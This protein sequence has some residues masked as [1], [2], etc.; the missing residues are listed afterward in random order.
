[1]RKTYGNTWWGKEFLNS[2]ANIDLTNLDNLVFS[3]IL[4]PSSNLAIVPGVTKLIWPFDGTNTTEMA[5]AD[6][7][8]TGDSMAWDLTSFFDNSFLRNFEIPADSNYALI[9]IKFNTQCLVLPGED[10][11][12]N[13]QGDRGCG[14]TH[15]S[16]DVVSTPFSVLGLKPKANRAV[17][18]NLRIDTVQACDTA[19][20]IDIAFYNMYAKVSRGSEVIAVTFPA[21]FD[22]VGS[23]YNRH[24]DSLLDTIAPTNTVTGNLRT[25]EWKLLPGMPIDPPWVDSL[26]FS[27]SIVPVTDISCSIDTL[28][29]AKTF[30]RYIL[31]CVS[32]SSVPC[33]VIYNLDD[34][35]KA[36]TVTKGEFGFDNLSAVL[37]GCNDSIDVAFDYTNSGSAIAA[38]TQTKFNI[39]ADANGNGIY[40]ITDPIIDSIV[41]TN[42]IPKGSSGSF[43]TTLSQTQFAGGEIC[44]LIVML[45]SNSSCVCDTTFAST[46]VSIDMQLVGDT[47]CDNDTS[48]FNVC[49]GTGNYAA[50]TYT[51]YDVNGSGRHIY[52][53]DVNS[54]SPSF[55]PPVVT[56]DSIFTFAIQVNRGGCVSEDTIEILVKAAP[57]PFTVLDD[58]IC[59]GTCANL[60]TTMEAGVTYNVYDG[61]GSFLGTLPYTACPSST[62]SY[63][64]EAVDPVTSCGSIRDTAIIT[65]IN[66]KDP[67]SNAVVSNCGIGCTVNLFS[68]LIGTPDTTGTWT[69]PSGAPFGIGH[70]VIFSSSTDVAGIYTYT[71]SNPPCNDTSSTVT[72]LQVTDT[73]PVTIPEDSTSTLCPPILSNLGSIDT[74]VVSCLP[75]NGT[76]T[77]DTMTGCMTYTPD[78]NYIGNDTLCVVTCDTLGI[79]DTAV[80]TITVVPVIDT[81]PLTVDEDDEVT[82]CPPSTTNVSPIGSVVV[83]CAPTHGTTSTDPTTGCVTYSP[84]SSYVGEDTLCIIICNT[85]GICDTTIVPITVVP[86]MDTVPTT[87][88]EDVPFTLCPPALTVV[89]SVG[90]FTL[91]C[92]PNNGTTS[93]DTA[94][95]CIT[96]TPS[97]NFSGLDTLCII[98]CDINGVC[99]TTLVPVTVTSE[100]DTIPVTIPE[101]STITLCPPVLSGVSPIGSISTNCGP[102]SGTV[103]LDTMTGCMTYKPD[104]NYVGNDTICVITCDTLSGICDTTVVT[105]TVTP[106]IDTVPVT[107]DEDTPFTICPPVTTSVDAIGSVTVSCGPNHGIPATDPTTG[108]VTYTPDSNYVGRD[109]ICIVT[110][111]TAGV[112]DTTIVP[113]TVVPVQDTL[114]KYLQEDSTITLCAPEITDVD[115]FD[116]LTVLCAPA[117]GTTSVDLINGCISY[118]ADPNFVG[119]DTLCIV[120]CDTNGICDTTIIEFVVGPVKDTLYRTILE[121]DSL[122][123]CPPVISNLGGTITSITSYCGPNQGTFTNDITTGCIVYKPDTNYVGQDSLCVVTCDNFSNCDTTIVI[124]TVIPVID[125]IPVTIPEDSS[126]TICPPNTTDTDVLGT[127]STVCGPNHG[128][129][130][131]DPITGCVSYEADS[132]YVGQDTICVVTCNSTGVCD[133]TPIVITVV[134][135]IDTL[136]IT[137]PED[138]SFTLCPP[139]L[140]DVDSIGTIT[141]G[142]VTSGTTTVDTATS[143]VT[144]N[145]NPSFSGR[146]TVCIIICDINGVCDT[147]IVPI[148]VTP[149]KD[150]VLVTI[151]ED[152]TTT[153]C[154]PVLSGISPIGS[155]ATFCDPAHGVVTLDTTTGCMTYNPDTNYVGQDSVCVVTCD[156]ISGVCDSTLVV[157]TITPVVDTVPVTIPEDSSYTLCPPFSTDVDNLGAAATI[158]GPNNGSVSI[159]F[160]TG[161]VTY[162]PDSSYVGQDTICILICNTSGVCDTTPL[163]ITIVP[164]I[165][166]VPVTIPEDSTITLCPPTVT[167][168]DSI[169]SVSI[170]CGP[171][172]GTTIIDSTTGC[173][174]YTPDSSFSGADTVCIVICNIDSICDTTVVV[175]KVTPETDSVPVVTLEDVPL[176]IA[177]PTLSGIT[178]I[179]TITTTGGPTHGT[180]TTDSITG[181]IT[182]TPDT[183]Y[184]GFDTVTVITCDTVANICDTTFVSITVLPV[185][186][187]VPMVIDE[188]SSFT[189][190][191]R[192]DSL[193]D[194]DSLGGTT[195][196]DG[197]NF[198]TTTVDP[199]TGAVTYKSD[200]NFVGRDSIVVE[201]CDTIAGFCDTTLITVFVKPV[202]DT[203]INDTIEIDTSLTLCPPSITVVDSIGSM[204][205][206]CPPMFGS[207]TFDSTT[208][209]VTYTPI[210]GYAGTDTLCFVIC[211]TAGV[212]DTTSLFVEILLDIDTVPVI[213]D[214][215]STFTLC[216]PLTTRRRSIADLDT[217]CSPMH[218]TVTLDTITGCVTYNPDTNYIGYDTVCIV[219]TDT[220]GRTDTTIITIT[221]NPILDTITLKVDEDTPLVIVPPTTTGF[222][223]LGGV[224]V[225]NGPKFGTVTTD[226]IT[227]TV[228]YVP[229][230]NFVGKDTIEIVITDGNGFSDTT[231]TVICVIPVRDTLY[232]SMPADSTI[233]VC[234]PTTTA[235]DSLGS[236]SVLC[237][238]SHGTATTDAAGCLTYIGDST[239]AGN[240]TLCVVICDTAGVCDTTTLVITLKRVFI[241]FT[242]ADDTICE[243]SCVTLMADTMQ[244]NVIY[245]VH[246]PRGTVIGRLPSATVCPTTDSTFYIEAYDTITGVASLWDTATIFVTKF[247]SP[248]IDT[249]IDLC[250]T[251]SI[252]N[253]FDSLGGTPDTT[254]TWTNPNGNPFGTRYPGSFDPLVDT[255][256]VYTYTI[257]NPVCPDTSATV[258]INKYDAPNPGM[259]DTLSF[260]QNGG[261]TDLFNSL[262]GTPDNTGNWSGPSTTINGHLGTIDLLTADT[263]LYWYKVAKRG[264]ADDS[265]HVKVHIDTIED[266]SIMMADTALCKGLESAQVIVLGAK[267]GTFSMNSLAGDNI[268]I[269]P[270]TGELTFSNRLPFRTRSGTYEVYY[271]TAGPCPE[272][273]TIVITM[274]E[275]GEGCQIEIPQLI[276]PNG[277]GK[278]DRF[279]IPGIEEFPNNV[280]KIYNRW[281]NL[282][283]EANRYTNDWEGKT[284]VN[285]GVNRTLGSGMLPVGTYFYIFEPNDDR[286]LPFSGYVYIKK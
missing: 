271:T 195:V 206:L 198:G 241:P 189:V 180:V 106:V 85:T 52:L 247:R 182:Y 225:T 79:C 110:C 17:D 138:S 95:S 209:C 161:C 218:G 59:A 183:N 267:G 33:E 203:I 41:T 108:C 71:I 248:G 125:T 197:P 53:S 234:M 192:T 72:I 269:D 279:I 26:S 229:D 68:S 275:Y 76:V 65:V 14:E 89:D 204:T 104:T 134:P 258:T 13:V 124:I 272:T 51:W 212:C 32:D 98:I 170:A 74:M 284:N 270:V 133:T 8:I 245:R 155:I 276:T 243:G 12:F 266:P 163:V 112:C 55:I 184:V 102:T 253:L 158:C 137:I 39:V 185:M 128:T 130:T 233:V 6:P 268:S 181:S 70:N 126:F 210:I 67:G 35:N 148:I 135:V 239:Y 265:A 244:S 160:A 285:T 84:D 174:T 15:L 44:N 63:Y 122:T 50:R 114:I 186:D 162:T 201:V 116:T 283:Y 123:I 219:T 61:L 228:T 73:I 227:G 221:I 232:Y 188:D 281:G 200:P 139:A 168:V 117:N 264:C 11:R 231:R 222:D 193:T 146:D 257:V 177:P 3:A 4:P 199:I 223:S 30:E 78:T 224:A 109:T 261:T 62:S 187:T 83:D 173:V 178:P 77:L 153:L 5:V 196:L 58:T 1:M 38:G 7:T 34:I 23:I 19:T 144:Y 278:N 235:V 166:T 191:P 115:V 80:V 69:D 60:T 99:D 149:E 31:Y 263:G 2:L 154:P 274:S 54:L 236:A 36:F 132:S 96:Y 213:I 282:V 131:I 175:V 165:D 111:N 252:V 141:I 20:Q 56:S 286:Y 120:K 93:I 208:G 216:P 280:L 260:C 47:I 92:G 140:T 29:E 262:L 226:P 82:I 176:T 256:G 43:S 101:D 18:I 129:V 152:S 88:K 259:S 40:D 87:T 147:T 237:L 127:V 66:K 10:I 105:V 45:D 81:V 167:V 171:T 172:H 246:S 242:V 150:T 37:N 143:C 86:V 240:D 273:E 119:Y 94:T 100:A 142:C 24:R 164:V 57:L 25:L 254:G 97:S 90:T 151:P 21:T 136:P 107:T 46:T 214:E 156:T 190:F 9:K 159:D 255:F 169:G 64:I 91:N 145:P 22:F 249:T 121:D 75:A 205:A 194:V 220:N 215:D 118:N 250:A 49:S 28:I 157:F 16:R 211:D 202:R 42:S 113:I 277:D 217:V 230:T 207:L 48:Q 179:G 27:F 251:G 238:P 103:T